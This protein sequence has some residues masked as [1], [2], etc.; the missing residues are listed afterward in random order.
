MISFLVA[1]KTH[2]LIGQ[3]TQFSSGGRFRSMESCNKIEMR[4][5]AEGPRGPSAR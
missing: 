3:T 2:F 1:K 4:P 5:G